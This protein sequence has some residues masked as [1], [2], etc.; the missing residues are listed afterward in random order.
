MSNVA[1][2]VEGLGKRYRI[3]EHERYFALRDVLSHAASA[4]LRLVGR[5]RSPAPKREEFWAL[6]D[7]SFEVQPGEVV[8]VIGRN[9]AG[10]STL[11]KILS[12]ITEPTKGEVDL[13]GRVGS[14]LEVG[15]GFHPELTG[16]ENIYLNGAILG[17]K[18]Q[19]I[20]RKFDEIVAFA[21]VEKFIDTPV[22]HYS[23]GMHMRLAFSV[24]AH[25]EPEILLVDEVLAVGDAEFQKRCLGRMG[26]LSKNGRTIVFVSHQLN[27]LRRLCDRVIWLDSGVVKLIGPAGR[28]VSAY[29][30]RSQAENQFGQE[31]QATLS[32]PARF[33]HWELADARGVTQKQLDTFDPVSLSFDVSVQ[34]SLTNVHHGI[35]LYG[36]DNRIVWG[37]GFDNLALGPG[38]HQ[39][40]YELPHLHLA[41]GYYTWLVTLFENG[42]L[43][44][45]W[46][47]IPQL[48]I[49]TPNTGH[50]LDA[51]SGILNFP[52]SCSLDGGRM[53]PQSPDGSSSAASTPLQLA[54]L[55]LAARK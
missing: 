25:L 36:P 53:T 5:G 51:W 26:E 40:R 55:V 48:H 16:R 19:E 11:L 28:T 27:E 13:H 38:T 1:I 8:G 47:A 37:T 4:P 7:V 34:R 15:T 43:L 46:Y 39:F 24:A 14:L 44:D 6:N 23:S 17:M 2:R 54:P 10:K 31:R 52:Y 33:T 3:G 35:V 21:D 29:E 20:A 41:P 32:A 9:G 18:R 49:A 12:R 50:K 45:S 30:S 22:K 42:H